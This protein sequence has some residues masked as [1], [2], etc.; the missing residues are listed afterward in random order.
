M[1]HKLAVSGYT[2]LRRVSYKHNRKQS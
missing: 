1:N 2:F